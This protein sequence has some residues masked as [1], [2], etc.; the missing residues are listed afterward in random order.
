MKKVLLC[1]LT[2]LLL[3]G[4][5]KTETGRKEPNT[6]SVTQQT[7][8]DSDWILGE[9]TGPAATE[10]PLEEDPK[11]LADSIHLSLLQNQ[12]A[13]NAQYLQ[14]LL[15][16]LSVSVTDVVKNGETL[17]VTAQ[18][19]APDMYALA[20][21]L[22]N[23]VFESGEEADAAVCRGMDSATQRTAT[24]TI[25]FQKEAGRWIPVMTEELVDACYGGLLTYQREYMEV[26]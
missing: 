11:A 21:S 4:C 26:D 24:V 14:K 18:I 9:G 23:V 15:E 7:P 2:A 6:G 12:L 5:T 25:V 17:T 16:M 10:A 8:K 19:T 22:E 1:L 20:K 13:G 3:C